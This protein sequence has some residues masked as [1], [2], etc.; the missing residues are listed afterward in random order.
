ML[1]P[2]DAVPVREVCMSVDNLPRVQDDM[3]LYDLLNKFQEGKS[4]FLC[5]D[6]ALMK[7]LVI[8]MMTVN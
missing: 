3:P 4:E 1:D 7:L 2:E 5:E 8:E 6:S